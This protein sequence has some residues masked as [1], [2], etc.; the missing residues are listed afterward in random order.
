MEA[1]LTGRLTQLLRS[2]KT[3]TQVIGNLISFAKPSGKIPPLSRIR[4]SLD[5]AGLLSR[6]EQRRCL[7]AMID[8]KV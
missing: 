1:V 5:N 3:I 4:S 2:G 7:C 6:I 8:R